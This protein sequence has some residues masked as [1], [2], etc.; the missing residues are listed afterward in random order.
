MG[1]TA[2]MRPEAT[3]VWLPFLTKSDAHAP[4]SAFVPALIPVKE[5]KPSNQPQKASISTGVDPQETPR[6]PY[7]ITVALQYA[8]LALVALSIVLSSLA[9][10]KLNQ[11]AKVVL[12]Q[13][14]TVGEVLKKLT[15]HPEAKGYFGA[16][17]KAFL[18]IDQNN[19]EMLAKQVPGLDVFWMGNY[20]VVYNDLLF[21]YNFEEDRVLTHLPLSPAPPQS[22][23][24]PS[25]PQPPQAPQQPKNP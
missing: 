19:L 24:G 13:N 17:P 7:E 3:P 21:V 10:I 8:I 5:N 22:S 15:A 25:P 20:L 16:K 18:R 12:R 14:P 11:V 9:A 6:T 1:G 2:K 23:P 4:L